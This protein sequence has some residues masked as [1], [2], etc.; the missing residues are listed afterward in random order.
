MKLNDGTFRG[1]LAGLLAETAD[2]ALEAAKGYLV[3]AYC[4]LFMGPPYCE[5]TSHEHMDRTGSTRVY[6]DMTMQ[7]RIISAI[8]GRR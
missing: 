6:L 5:T 1:D 8:T 2:F 3:N 4:M 7:E